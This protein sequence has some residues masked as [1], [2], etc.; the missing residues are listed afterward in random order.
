MKRLDV[1]GM[2]MMMGQRR[3][4]FRTPEG[5]SSKTKDLAATKERKKL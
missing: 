1:V 2:M 4:K 5:A 3:D